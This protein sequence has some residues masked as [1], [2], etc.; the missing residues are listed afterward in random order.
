MGNSRVQV[1]GEAPTAPT[2]E[3]PRSRFWERLLFGAVVE[4]A[5]IVV[6]AKLGLP[7]ALAVRAAVEVVKAKFDF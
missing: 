5:L 4:V 3:P 7:V 2:P 6:E 1:Q